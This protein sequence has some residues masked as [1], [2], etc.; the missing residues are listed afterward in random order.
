MRLRAY[1]L[2]VLVVA[3]WGSTFVLIKGALADATPAAFN[4]VRMT[5]AFAVLAVVYPSFSRSSVK[6]CAS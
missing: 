3:V 6:I 5:L 4:L 2:M 1:V